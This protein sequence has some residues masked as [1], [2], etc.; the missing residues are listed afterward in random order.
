MVTGLGEFEKIAREQRPYLY[1]FL[2]AMCGDR[3]DAD[4]LVQDTLIRA[5]EK[6]DTFRHESSVRTWLTRIAINTFLSSRRRTR[7]HQ[8]MSLE[9]LVV[10]ESADEPERLVERREFQWCIYH[11]IFHHV[12]ER[13]RAALALRDLHGASYDEIAKA[14]G[15]S[16]QAARLK[17][18]RGR[19]SF[20]EH[21][22]EGKCYAF[23]R[24][25]ACI[26]EGIKELGARVGEGR[27]G[28]KQMV[29]R[30]LRAP[31]RCRIG[32]P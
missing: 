9:T 3:F 13:Y 10:R 8:S 20:R 23:T 30:V 6:R 29:D 24:D 4:D 17:V 32:A 2:Y 11:T 27:V 15:C 14:L 5:Y 21:F 28:D 26:C 12:P 31:A 25:Y 22:V 18:H 16:A 19:K 7:P 1:N